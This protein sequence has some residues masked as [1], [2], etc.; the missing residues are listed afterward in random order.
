MS[1][2]RALA[3]EA[4]R[5]RRL[6]PRSL[7]RSGVAPLSR[8][9]RILANCARCARD[10]ALGTADCRIDGGLPAERAASLGER[11]TRYPA[12]CRSSSNSQVSGPSSE[13]PGT[14]PFAKEQRSRAALLLVVRHG[15]GHRIGLRRSICLIPGAGSTRSATRRYA[16]SAKA[17]ARAAFDFSGLSGHDRSTTRGTLLPP[18]HVSPGLNVFG[19]RRPPVLRLVRPPPPPERPNRSP[20][21]SPAHGLSPLVHVGLSMAAAPRVANLSGLLLTPSDRRRGDSHSSDEP[22][23]ATFRSL[24]LCPAAQSQRVE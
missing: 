6:E 5:A 24:D 3:C 1:F 4:R 19:V 18:W 15:S 9:N 2:C 23:T 10:W 12:D 11:L 21:R 7:A 14:A 22:R 17:P 20:S 13:E 8:R 16:A